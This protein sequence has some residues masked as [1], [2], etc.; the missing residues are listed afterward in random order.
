MYM[1]TEFVECFAKRKIDWVSR[2]CQLRYVEVVVLAR[3]YEG[4]RRRYGAL[5]WSLTRTSR[6]IHSQVRNADI[7]DQELCQIVVC[8]SERIGVRLRITRLFLYL[9]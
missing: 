3:N 5:N 1:V 6:A 7:R 4:E 9:Q 8:D 2:I